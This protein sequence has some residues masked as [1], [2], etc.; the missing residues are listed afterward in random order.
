MRNKTLLACALVCCGQSFAATSDSTSIVQKP[1]L[2]QIHKLQCTQIRS[3]GS[4]DCKDAG[5]FDSTCAVAKC[6]AGTVLTGG[7]GACAAGDRRLK[8]LNANVVTGEYSV[9]CEKQG[10]APQ[11]SAICCK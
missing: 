3:M 1:P 2:M 7:G 9:M 11:A 10:V 6:P 4:E 5:N 8:S